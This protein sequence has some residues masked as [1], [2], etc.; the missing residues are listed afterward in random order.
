MT[1]I[2]NKILKTSIFAISSILFLAGF[3]NFSALAAQKEFVVVIDAGHGGK[4]HGAIDNNA[5]EKDIN[6]AVALRLGDLIEKK[7]KNSEVVF[8]RDNDSF[9]SLQGRAD[10]ANKAKGDLFI[11][12]HTNSVDASNKNRA[13]IEGASVYTLGVQK[14]DANMS[15][16]RRE[17]SV[18]ELESGSGS[19]YSGF[20]PNKDESYIIFEM[21]QKN[22]IAQSNRFA[23]MVQDNLVKIAGRKDRG[24]RQAGFWVL[25]S[26]SMPSVLVEL[27]FICNPDAAKFMTSKEGVDK[28]AEAIFQA[29]KIYEQNFR[30]S[31][32]MAA[33]N[34]AGNRDQTKK[35]TDASAKGKKKN[36]DKKQLKVPE[37]EVAEE[38][39]LEEETIEPGSP[40]ALSFVP[41]NCEKDMSHSELAATKNQKRARHSFDG[42][43]RRSSVAKTIS[44]SRNL[45]GIVNER[46]EFT[47][48]S[49]GYTDVKAEAAKSE[50]SADAVKNKKDIKKSK[51]KIST[52]KYADKK[53]AS[54]KTLSASATEK[55]KQ[56]ASQSNKAA[57]SNRKA[58]PKNDKKAREIAERERI[59]KERMQKEAAKKSNDKKVVASKNSDSN[60]RSSSNI[61]SAKAEEKKASYAK[62]SIKKGAENDV[63]SE[64]HAARRKSLR[65]K[66][67][68]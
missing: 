13:S 51:K 43:R 29:V 7:I 21:A 55:S 34:S 44:D 36:N 30:Q 23:K 66:S 33:N 2:C 27:D 57:N 61:V 20:D 48:R 65:S 62:G 37:E 53:T 15:V 40:I 42:R 14:D 50:E 28:M 58:D 9:V 19:K 12:I 25:W 59:Q 35:V 64:Q 46:S 1:S 17:N 49:I 24:V 32:R 11:S 5:R 52:K 56:S 41:E 45:E 54:S 22:N 4:D 47:G 6:L 39:A 18:I 26:T 68:D 67:Q 16:A 8:T 10:I 63:N 38:V 60:N 31:L 3:L